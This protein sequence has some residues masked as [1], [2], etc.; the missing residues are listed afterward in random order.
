MFTSITVT[1]H[2]PRWW[3]L[4]W[5]HY[6]GEH[7][8]G[9]NYFGEQGEHCEMLYFVVKGVHCSISPYRTV[10]TVV[11]GQRTWLFDLA[12]QSHCHGRTLFSPKYLLT[13]FF[14]YKYGCLWLTEHRLGCDDIKAILNRI[15]IKT[16]LWPNLPKVL[17]I[18]QFW[19][20]WPKFI[21][22]VNNGLFSFILFT[23]ITR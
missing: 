5:K 16:N 14:G 17:F 19:Q 23:K 11:F 21:S 3:K 10:C 15:K 6:L 4:L 7:L 12:K 1:N 8:F 20:T 9:E 18:H 13:M 22:V 2:P